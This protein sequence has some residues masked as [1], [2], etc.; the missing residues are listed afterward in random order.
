MRL[1]LKHNQTK[2]YQTSCVSNGLASN[3]LW[4]EIPEET[5]ANLQGGNNERIRIR[6]KPYDHLTWAM[7]LMF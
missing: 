1:I 6:L 4:C 3:N 7:S 2:D 5:Q